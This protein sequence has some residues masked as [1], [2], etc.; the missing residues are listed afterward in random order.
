MVRQDYWDSVNLQPGGTYA[1]APKSAGFQDMLAQ[2]AP[3]HRIFG[4]VWSSRTQK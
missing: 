2:L 3:A 4:T 1:P